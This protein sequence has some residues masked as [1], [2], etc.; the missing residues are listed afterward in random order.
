MALVMVTRKRKEQVEQFQKLQSKMEQI[1]ADV[2][3]NKPDQNK[4][5]FDLEDR[6]FAIQKIAHRLPRKVRTRHAYSNVAGALADKRLL[7]VEQGCLSI[8]SVPQALSSF[9]EWATASS[10]ALQLTSDR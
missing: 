4:S 6:P 9:V 3:N 2:S 1:Y 8:D 10:S 7:L 5:R